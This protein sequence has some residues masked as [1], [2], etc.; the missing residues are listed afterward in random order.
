MKDHCADIE[1]DDQIKHLFFVVNGVTKMDDT[2]LHQ[3]KIKQSADGALILRLLYKLGDKDQCPGSLKTQR[4][5]VWFEFVD[6]RNMFVF[7]CNCSMKINESQSEF[8]VASS[9]LFQRAVF[10]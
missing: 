8:A 1:Q 10:S 5:F 9:T 2:T 6:I 3:D 4:S 7:S